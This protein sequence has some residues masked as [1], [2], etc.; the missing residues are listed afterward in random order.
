MRSL[1]HAENEKIELNQ[2]R[3][4]LDSN[5]ISTR[6]KAAKRVC[7]LMRTG[8]KDNIALLFSSMLRCVKTDDIELK[9]LV[10]HYIVTYSLE[11][12]EQSIMVVNTFIQDMED[13]N[14]LIQALAI[15]TMS[16]IKIDTVAESMIIPLK[17]V[18]QDRDPYVRKTAALAVSKLFEV[19]PEAVENSDLFSSLISLLHDDNPMVISNTT[20]S[21]LEINERRTTPI[22]IFNRNTITPVL[23]AI[24]NSSCWCQTILFDTLA[25][26]EPEDSEEALNLIDRLI[27]LLKSADAMVVIGAFKCIFLFMD[28]TDKRPQDLFSSIVPPFIGLV[29]GN[30]ADPEIQYVVLRTLSLFVCKFPKALSKEVRLFFCKYNDPSY[31]KMEKL[32]IIVT[33]ANASNVD[34]VLDEFNE[35]TNSVDVHFVRKTIKCIGQIALKLPI[36]SRRCVSILVKLVEGKAEYAVEESI[37]VLCDLLRKYP[38]DFESVIGTI[39]SKAEYVKD[40]ESK[41]SL[42]WILGEYCGLIEKVDVLLDPFLDTFHDEDPEVQLQIITAV[43]KA[44][45]E[46]LDDTKDQLQYVLNEATKESILPDVKNRAMLYWR[47]LSMDQSAARRVCLFTKESV[48]H[49]GNQFTKEVLTEL[50][51]N[52]GNA[53]GV[54]HIVPSSFVSNV[55]LFNP[56]DDDDSSR[57][58]RPLPLRNSPVPI[59]INSDWDPE[60]YYLQVINRSTEGQSLSY[61]ALALNANGA[62]FTIDK[63]I[64]FP[65]VLEPNDEFCIEIPFYFSKDAIIPKTE[66]NSS[67]VSAVSMDF[68]LRTSAGNLF[69]T[70]FIDFRSITKPFKMFRKDFLEKWKSETLSTL[71]FNLSGVAIADNESLR[72]RRIFVLGEREGET[73]VAF[74]LAPDL[75]Y[76]ADLEYD[77]NQMRITLKGNPSRFPFIQE[78]AKYAFCLD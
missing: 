6:K 74:L 53:S 44:Y 36:A 78:S 55:Q 54:L 16:R 70:D 10:Y 61:F 23:S 40:P 38:G 1:F 56:D 39:C 14:P 77:G 30:A 37:I 28:Y 22:H 27:P 52:M 13:P 64:D 72:K 45:L 33:I 51:R 3:D 17:K 68:A 8:D 18:L 20:A 35:Y 75:V 4:A 65:D 62:G 58:W 9:R 57:K 41:S 50:L 24:G 48:E 59:E 73:C 66:K 12:S 69:F 60:K 71:Q 46:K 63:N 47:L 5:D 49:S 34:L 29:S 43:V 7:S 2:L 11:E 31:I 15:R 26:Y 21:I 67:T 32:Y 42:I 25:K 19:I 76:L